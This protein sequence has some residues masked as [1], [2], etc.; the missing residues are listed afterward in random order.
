MSPSS[1]N[2][3]WPIEMLFLGPILRSRVTTSTVKIDKCVL[4]TI[5]FLF[6]DKNAL[7]YSVVVVNSEVVGLASGV[8]RKVNLVAFTDVKTAQNYCCNIYSFPRQS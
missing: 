8:S 1:E 7:A 4:K 6:Y 2:S 5:F 3:F